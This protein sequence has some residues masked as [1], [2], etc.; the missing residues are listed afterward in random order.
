MSVIKVK[1][2]KKTKS[3]MFC[4]LRRPEMRRLILS[5]CS[6]YQK[7]I[8]FY[9]SLW[10]NGCPWLSIGKGIFEMNNF[11]QMYFNKTA[12]EQL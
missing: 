6:I 5:K 10:S 8:I 12:A 11:K 4:H 2:K 9:K 3:K 1:S 7:Y